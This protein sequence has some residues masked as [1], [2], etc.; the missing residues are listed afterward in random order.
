M[1]INYAIEFYANWQ[2]ASFGAFSR[3]III[4]MNP[5]NH[6]HFN[7]ALQWI[8]SVSSYFL[9]LLSWN[10]LIKFKWST[11][12]EK[13]TVELYINSKRKPG[14]NCLESKCNGFWIKYSE[15]NGDSIWNERQPIPN[16][17]EWTLRDCVVAY[18]IVSSYIVTTAAVVELK[19]TEGKKNPI[20]WSCSI[21]SHSIISGTVKSQEAKKRCLFL[22]NEESR[23]KM[24]H[25]RNVINVI[26]DLNLIGARNVD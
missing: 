11:S 6:I 15:K 22:W 24:T 5:L 1:N 10:Y 9:L 19:R 7:E 23:N 4:L 8:R 14:Q 21:F 13:K 18:R 2:N 20:K 12:S 17:N 25:I 26:E 3:W 16:S